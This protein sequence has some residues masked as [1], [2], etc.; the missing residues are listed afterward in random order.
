MKFVNTMREE[1]IFVGN[2]CFHRLDLNKHVTRIRNN[3][4]VKCAT[5][6]YTTKIHVTSVHEKKKLFKCEMR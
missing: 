5:T 3:S 2:L 4:N 1:T 6:N